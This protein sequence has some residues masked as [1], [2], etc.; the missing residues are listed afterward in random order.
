MGETSSIQPY[1]KDTPLKPQVEAS[2][3]TLASEIAAGNTEGLERFLSFAARFPRRS[4]FNQWLLLQQAPEATLVKTYDEWAALGYLPARGAH[5]L[6]I[7]A[8]RA[9]TREIQDGALE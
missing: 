5:G 1:E 6:R 7:L 2:I 8:S 9:W 4:L 3:E